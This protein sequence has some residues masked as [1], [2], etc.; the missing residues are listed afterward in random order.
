MVQPGQVLVFSSSEYF[1][2]KSGSEGSSC[3]P[4]WGESSSAPPSD[5]GWRLHWCWCSCCHSS[6][7]CSIQNYCTCD[8]RTQT[9]E[10]SYLSSIPSEC[11]GSAPFLMAVVDSAV[12][13]AV[14]IQGHVCYYSESGHCVHYVDWCCCCYCLSSLQCWCCCCCW[15]WDIAEWGWGPHSEGWLGLAHSHSSDLGHC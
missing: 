11:W 4:G 10:H 3:V 2:Q 12:D 5:T 9:Q 8:Y 1:P 14:G 7:Y 13:S 6:Q 15:G